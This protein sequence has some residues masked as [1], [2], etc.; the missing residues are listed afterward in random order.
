MSLLPLDVDYTARDFDALQDRLERSIQSVFPKWTDFEASSF[1][2]ILLE[3]IC[4]V[5]DVLAVY[6]DGIA[7]EAF[8]STC[9][10]RINAIRHC[11]AIGYTL[12]G[13]S[14]AQVDLEIT[15]RKAYLGDVTFEA[16]K[17][18]RSQSATDPARVQLLSDLTILAGNLTGTVTAEHSLTHVEVFD[19]DDQADQEFELTQTP[20]LEVS[21]LLDDVGAH[22]Q[23]ST[24]LESSSTDR[25]YLRL[26]SEDNRGLVKMGDGQNGKVPSGEILVTYKTGGGA[27]TIEQDTLVQ[28]E[29][30]AASSLGEAVLF[31]VTNPDSATGGLP[32]ETVD[33]ARING[34]ASVRVNERSVSKEDFEIN[35]RRISG[36][37]RALMLTS[38]QDASIQENRG[39]LYLVAR[40]ATTAS[41]LYLPA[42]PTAGQ[43]AQVDALIAGTYPPCLTFSFTTLAAPF[44]TIDITAR[45]WLQEGASPA[46]VDASIRS[47]LSDYFAAVN[48][49]GTPTTTIDFGYNYT[50]EVGES[51][52]FVPWG[53]IFQAIRG[54]AGVRK[55]D[56]DA[57]VPSDDVLL[58]SSE[59]PKLGTVT[60]V[61]ARTGLALV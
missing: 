37:D 47:N 16:G 50:D 54:T 41:G 17:I 58:L 36:V 22:T 3:C 60:L 10:S 23:V 42:A 6:E 21:S 14:A 40:G 13:A 34:P 5:G 39:F 44:N 49:N 2:N 26:S 9:V 30:S 20:F 33:E 52:P 25:H 29:F 1:A 32:Q 27:I 53:D 18:V 12:R 15:L 8:L 19:S 31:D 51:D 57:Q 28:P 11:R 59:F 4:F 38:D 7:R 56:E 61:N 24:F 55:V 45:L 43:I 46:T 35:A 48:A